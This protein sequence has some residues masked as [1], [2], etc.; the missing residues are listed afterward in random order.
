MGNELEKVQEK[1]ETWDGNGEE[2]ATVYKKNANH[3]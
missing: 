1:K 2:A 3:V